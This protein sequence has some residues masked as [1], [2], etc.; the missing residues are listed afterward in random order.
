MYTVNHN[1]YNTRY[2]LPEKSTI[3][4]IE[5]ENKRSNGADKRLKAFLETTDKLIVFCFYL[6]ASY[7]CLYSRQDFTDVLGWVGFF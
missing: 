7:L 5:N 3:N 1:I 2:F 6:I 4:L